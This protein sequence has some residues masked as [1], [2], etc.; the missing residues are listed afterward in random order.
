MKMKKIIYLSIIFL[1]I[2]IT[3]CKPDKKDDPSAPTPSTDARDKFIAYWN[4]NETSALA[5]GNTFT[6]NIIK[7][8]TSSSEVI[9]NNYSGL[10]VSARASVNNSILT[11]PYQSIGTPIIGF[12][13]GTGTL[14]SATTIS[15]N[16]TTTIS[17]SRDS[18][19]AIYTKQ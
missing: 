14:T 8:T 17:T 9:I 2:T 19:S 4:V 12:T 6:V 11:I 5:G 13:Q 3:S 10:S 7:S 15:L 18:C 16:Y 1:S